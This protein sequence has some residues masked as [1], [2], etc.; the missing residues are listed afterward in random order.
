M[1][2][3]CHPKSPI[4]PRL[5]VTVIGHYMMTSFTLLHFAWNRANHWRDLQSIDVTSRWRE[6]WQSAM[7]VNY[8]LVVDPT[9][10]L[11]GFDLHR[12]QWSLLNRFRTGHGHCNACHKKWGFTDNELCDCG[13][14]QTMSHIVN[15]CPLTK[16]DGGLLRLHE[17]DEAAVDWL[18]TYGS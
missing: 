6:D 8:T 10:R 7:V 11:P 16:F 12:R 9:I 17:A 5:N 15:S 2:R 18:T 4:T 13:E 1:Y 3:W 14:I